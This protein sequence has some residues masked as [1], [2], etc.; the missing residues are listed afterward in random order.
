[1]SYVVTFIA[2]AVVASIAWFLI[3][4]NNQCKVAELTA[5]VNQLIGKKDTDCGC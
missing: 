1:M 2:G 4:R 3:Y 5:R